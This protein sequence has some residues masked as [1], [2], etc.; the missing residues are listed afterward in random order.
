[1]FQT[2]IIPA[3]LS[4]GIAAAV[5]LPGAAQPTAAAFLAEVGFTKGQ[6]AQV[7]AGDF[8]AAEIKPSNPREIVAAFAFLAQVNPTGLVN[9][10]EQGLIDKTDSNTIAFQ[11]LP[12][13]PTLEHFQK[14][15]LQP[16][17]DQRAKAYLNAKPGSDLNLSSE[18]IAAF[19]K[20]GASATTPA[21]EQ[22]VRAALLARLQ[23]YQ[24]NGLTG[25]APYAR[26]GGSRSP[27]DD[28][29]SATEASKL[30]QKLVP[31]AYQLFLDYPKGLPV[32]AKDTYRWEHLTA[33]GTPTIALTHILY[34]NEGIAWTILQRQFYV[35]TG[36]NSEQAVVGFL[37][38]QKGTLVFYT[39]RT[40]TDQVEGFGGG[41][42]RSIGSKLL[43]SEL[44]TLYR[45]ARIPH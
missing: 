18:E 28:L 22:Q 32:G 36:Y 21:V 16:G 17:A 33:H 45:K 34:V 44:E 14:L 30:L 8:V 42:K 31:K 29:R 3:A 23:A 26:A 38:M 7:E 41:A 4:F 20:L 9:L 25:I 10:L 19:Q 37:P 24:T 11:L 39:N 27:A 15:T 43:A 35:S 1:M 2:R 13:A 40:S 12:P 5:A 6:I